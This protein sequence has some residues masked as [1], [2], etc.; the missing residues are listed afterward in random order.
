GLGIANDEYRRVT[1][2]WVRDQA[3]GIALVVDRGG[4]TAESAD[5]LRSSGF[6]ARLLHAADDPAADP[7]RLLIVVVKLD[8]TADDARTEEKARQDGAPRPWIE[9]F[10]EACGRATEMVR[11][12]LRRELLGF[13]ESQDGEARE[14]MREVI[15]HVLDT[16][17]VHAVAALEYRKW[18]EADED[19]PARIKD[20]AHCN[21]PAFAEALRAVAL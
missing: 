1:Q 11:L 18:L 5:L 7:V 8:Q 10:R 21:I 4:V 19:E 3:R 20:P 2:Q 6:L 12:Q 14:D 17:E 9:H 16:V 13:V 15:E